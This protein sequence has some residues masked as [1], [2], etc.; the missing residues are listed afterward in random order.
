MKKILK[1][2]LLQITLLSFIFLI[3]GIDSI[4]RNGIII[5]WLAICG[6]LYWLCRKYIT[7]RDL[8]RLTE[9]KLFE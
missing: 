7:V 1:V 4:I 2:T 3:I 5:P 6:I 9:Y 8:Y